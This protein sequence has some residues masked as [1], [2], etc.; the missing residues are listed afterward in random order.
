MKLQTGKVVMS[1]NCDSDNCKGQAIGVCDLESGV[2][3]S[4]VSVESVCRADGVVDRVVINKARAEE[5]GFHIMIDKPAQAA[6]QKNDTNRET[7]IGGIIFEHEND[8]YGLWEGFFLTEE[9]EDAIWQIL[10]KHETQGCS[11]R[12]TRKD[13][14]K[15]IGS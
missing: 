5:H 12:G 2:V 7:R 9:E 6:E 1:W 8:D 14:A 13:I 15:E 3:W 11:V 10:K 4:I